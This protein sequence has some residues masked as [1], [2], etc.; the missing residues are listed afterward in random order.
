[1]LSYKVHVIIREEH[2]NKPEPLYS[3][4]NSQEYYIVCYVQRARRSDPFMVQSPIHDP[5]KLVRFVHPQA[6]RNCNYLP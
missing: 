4:V 1:M 6:I 3:L 5:H 2:Y